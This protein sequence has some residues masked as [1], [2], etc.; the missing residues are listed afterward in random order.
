MTSAQYKDE[1]E[2][3]D[4]GAADYKIAKKTL[5]NVSPITGTKMASKHQEKVPLFMAGK[6]VHL[7]EG[8]QKWLVAA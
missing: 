7:T 2:E 5:I 3:L 6:I 4:T 8:S 1:E